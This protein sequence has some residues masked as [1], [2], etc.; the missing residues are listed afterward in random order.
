MGNGLVNSRSMDLTA[1]RRNFSPV[2][3]L[4]LVAAGLSVLYYATARP[5]LL[6]IDGEPLQLRT[7]ARRPMELLHEAGI[8]PGPNDA[9]LPDSDTE[10]KWEDGVLPV[11]ELIQARPVVLADQ[12]RIRLIETAETDSANLIAHQLFPG[13]RLIVNGLPAGSGAPSHIQLKRAIPIRLTV[14]G[15]DRLLHSAAPTLGE[16]LWESGVQLHE[17]DQLDPLPNTPLDGPMEARLERST[18]VYIRVAGREIRGRSAADTVEGA[19]ADADLHPVGLDYTIP[20]EAEALPADGQIQLVRVREEMQM[21]Q[22]PLSF[23]TLYQ[24]IDTLEIDNQQMVQP[25]AYGV[26]TNR[27]R[28]RTEDGVEVSRILEG[29]WV[30]QEPIPQIIGYGT[31]IQVRTVATADGPLDYWRAIEMYATSY[32]PSRAGVSPDARWFG[33]TASGKRLKKGLVAIDRSLIP[34]G[35]MMYVPGYGFAEAADSG[36]GVKGRWIDLGYEDDNWVSWSGYV[37]VY[38]LTPIPPP[39]SIVFIFP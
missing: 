27:L 31:Q 24:P 19:L 7:H 20:D 18:P 39:E 33:I 32:S 4:V 9:L 2:I 12:G 6:V 25:G 30:A 14:D 3:P 16:A 1:A 10:L 15:R 28:V 35:T 22:E 11:I 8:V 37:T 13:D 23:D 17:G 38:F 5:A 36:S 29:E 26:T 34:F 21:E